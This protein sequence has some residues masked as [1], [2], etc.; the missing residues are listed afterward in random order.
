MGIFL[1]HVIYEVIKDIISATVPNVWQS[2]KTNLF[3]DL[4]NMVGF[5]EKQDTNA[6]TDLNVRYLIK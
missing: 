1:S 6:G 3:Y 4:L 2:Y 5:A